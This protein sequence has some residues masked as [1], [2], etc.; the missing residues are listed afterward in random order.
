[1]PKRNERLEEAKA[2]AER[3]RMEIMRLT[4]KIEIVLS[5]LQGKKE[6]E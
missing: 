4:Q 6:G 2:E 5:V 1:M 3:L